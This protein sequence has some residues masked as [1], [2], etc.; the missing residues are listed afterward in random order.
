MGARNV[1]GV[2]MRVNEKPDRPVGNFADLPEE[3]GGGRRGP[4]GVDQDEAVRRDDH[5]AVRVSKIALEEVEPVRDPL[6]PLEAGCRNGG[7]KDGEDNR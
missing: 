4:L 3:I 2:G 7:R 5:P 1:V 6:Q